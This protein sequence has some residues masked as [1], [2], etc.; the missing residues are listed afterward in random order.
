ML[1]SYGVQ[2]NR[3]TGFAGI[4]SSGSD[5]AFSGHTG[6]QQYHGVDY[7]G[8]GSNGGSVQQQ[9]QQMQRKYHTDTAQTQAPPAAHHH[10]TRSST[11]LR[12]RP[13][14]MSPTLLLLAM[15]PR[16]GTTQSHARHCTAKTL[17]TAPAHHAHADK[18][19]QQASH[20]SINS[21]CRILLAR[22]S[23]TPYLYLHKRNHP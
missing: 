14:L 9:Q 4:P 18:R 21:R 16:G 12:P 1:Q 2:Y 22:I 13:Q 10:A 11:P 8:S 17:S 19:A 3:G 5:Q 20:T 6:Q 7:N 23:S 15:T